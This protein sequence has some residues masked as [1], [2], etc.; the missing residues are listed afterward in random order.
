[1]LTA[2][3]QAQTTILVDPAQTWVGYMN[4]FALPADGGGYQF[5]NAW[6][7]S[8]LRAAFAGDLLVLS[9]CTNVSSPTDSYWVKPDGSGNK[10]MNANWYVD[11]TSLVGSNVV[12]AGNVV[13]YTLTSNYT[14]RAVI[15]VFPS[16]Y[17]SI[18]Q[19]ASAPLTNGNLFFQVALEANQPG[20]AHVQYGFELIGPNAPCTNSPDSSG[21]ISIRTNALDPRNVLANAG[22]ENGLSGWTPYGNG[23][24]IETTANTYY[25]GGNPVGASN[26]LVYEGIKVQKVFPGFTGGA[27]YNGIYQ[28]QP[29]GPGSTWSASARCLTH[30]QDLIG[31]ADPDGTNQ[32]WL[33]ISFRD[34]TDATLA[35]FKSPI[36][37]ASSPVDTWLDMQV[38][39]DI[40]G[41]TVLTAPEGT[42]KVRFQEVLYQPYGYAGGSV[43]ADHM[44]LDN[45]SPSDP[46]ITTPPAN[47]TVQ[48]GQTASFTVVATGLTPLHYQWSVN[49]ANLVDGPNISGATSNT[50]TLGNV[51]K[52]QAGTYSVD[53]SDEAG[54]MRVSATLTVKTAAEAANAL[55]NPSFESGVYFPWITF[56]GGVLVTNDQ[57]WGGT[58]VSNY[59]GIVGSVVQG[60]AEYCGAYQDVPASPG[61]IFTADGWFFEPSSFALSASNQVWLEVQF[62]NGTTPLALYKS[63]PIS[64]EDPARPL[65]VWY[66]LQATNGFAGDFVT[67]IDNAVYLVAPPGT[68]QVRYQVTMHVVGGIGG[69][70]YDAM[71]LLNKQPVTLTARLVAAHIDISWMSQGAMSYQVLYKTNLNDAEWTSIDDPIPGDGSLKVVS[72]PVTTGTRF[73]KLRIQ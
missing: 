19:Q 59:D 53:V 35:T 20:A 30:H 36:L 15:K 29:A 45:L 72:Y 55:E 23:G 16:D 10:Q 39:N 66:N 44:V 27:N 4:V 22:F 64:A 40:E 51:Q 38:T 52:Y 21:F 5:G 73:Y 14:A 50:L 42:A 48:V 47:Q 43:Y 68:T 46:N 56:N 32:F 17:S 58:V 57:E 33:E 67:P 49:D 6:A 70:I 61:M 18:L 28:D 7:G 34:A 37:D 31:V 26:V 13:E 62:R 12:F 41:G 63:Y 25:N 2:A 65:D 8:D 69:V 71:Q 1:M 3:V 54:T 60:G 11:T 9:P 24:N